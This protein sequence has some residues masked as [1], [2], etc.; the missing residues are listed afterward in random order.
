MENNYF[1]KLSVKE[2]SLIQKIGINN[3]I[4]NLD[5]LKS[6]YNKF[7]QGGEIENDDSEV[8]ERTNNVDTTPEFKPESWMGKRQTIYKMHPEYIDRDRQYY[9]EKRAEMERKKTELYNRRLQ[10]A[11][12]INSVAT[13]IQEALNNE[14][15]RQSAIKNTVSTG[16]KEAVESQEERAREKIYEHKLMLNSLATAGEILSSY[17]ML[18]K[19]ARALKLL[20]NSTIIDGLYKSD[21]GQVIASTIGTLSDS[22]QLLTADTPK[23]YIE[24]S[25][26][27]PADVAGIIGGTNWF[28][29]T[30][31]FGKYGK[32]VD[33]V[34]DFMGYSAA[35]Y[36]GIIK[37]I[38]W[39]WDSYTK[40]K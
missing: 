38:N 5:I 13:K 39:F 11:K 33:N 36:D 22:Y 9:I 29:N 19:G 25:L 37:P 2:K 32:T 24:N 20:P 18:G 8:S 4:Y 35:S 30:P 16:I 26:E 12:K 1:D 40:D 28:R 15:Q 7:A 3:S 27:I 23:D 34:M 21:R 17:Y 31:F 6:L 14:V 10:R